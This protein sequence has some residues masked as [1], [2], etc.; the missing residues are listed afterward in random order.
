MVHSINFV[1]VTDVRF[2]RADS[3]NLG[4]LRPDYEKTEA[5]SSLSSEPRENAI[6]PSA[7]RHQRWRFI[8][9]L[10]PVMITLKV[11]W[12]VTITSVSLGIEGRFF[13]R[14]AVAVD[15]LVGQRRR[16]HPEDAGGIYHK[17]EGVPSREPPPSLRGDADRCVRGS[18]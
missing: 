10:L 5:V 6:L 7:K 18:G 2:D 13:A 12:M 17:F 9:V 15:E 3:V 14:V 16:G 8:V 11:Q 4:V 1:G